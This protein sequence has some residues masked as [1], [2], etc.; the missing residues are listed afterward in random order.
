MTILAFLYAFG[1]D[2]E[3]TINAYI[4]KVDL[5][6]N[7]QVRDEYQQLIEIQTA[8]AARKRI[9]K[10]YP[11]LTRKQINAIIDPIEKMRTN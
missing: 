5:Q 2:L 6:I 7:Q 10:R 8:I 4:R 11:D 1:A 3:A 9:R